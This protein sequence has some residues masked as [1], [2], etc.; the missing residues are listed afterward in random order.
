[1]YIIY[2]KD[3]DNDKSGW[4]NIV[5]RVGRDV[6]GGLKMEKRYNRIGSNFLAIPEEESQQQHPLKLN[7]CPS[8]TKPWRSLVLCMVSL[9]SD[10]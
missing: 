1:M 3:E 7:R 2:N 10:S 4:R 9:E 5:H 8:L 6:F